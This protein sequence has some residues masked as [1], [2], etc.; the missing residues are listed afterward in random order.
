MANQRILI[1]DDE[2]DIRLVLR[3]RLERDGYSVLEARDGAEA[4][5]MARSEMPDLIVLDVMMPEMDGVEVCN[6]LRASFTTRGI[7]VIM[8]T[9]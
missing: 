9:A 8:L 5:A 6:R 1:A 2:P 3:T 7:P 4:V